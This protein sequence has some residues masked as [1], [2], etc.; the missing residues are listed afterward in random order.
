M[1]NCHECAPTFCRCGRKLPKPIHQYLEKPISGK[2]WFIP[3]KCGIWY[4]WSFHPHSNG[5]WKIR[6]RLPLFDSKEVVAIA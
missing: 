5:C 2:T 1:R 3:C 6:S 4:V